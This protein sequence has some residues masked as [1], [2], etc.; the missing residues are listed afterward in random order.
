MRRNGLFA[1]AVVLLIIGGIAFFIGPNV[2]AIR[3]IA[4][5]ARLVSVYLIRLSGARG[6]SALGT[7][8]VGSSASKNPNRSLWVASAALLLAGVVAFLC[9]LNDAAHGYHQVWPVYF[10]AG[11]ACVCIVVWSY[12]AASTR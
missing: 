8:V 5:G 10:F 12:L 9:L 11:V 7:D 1:L 3:P 6:R 2:P 4:I